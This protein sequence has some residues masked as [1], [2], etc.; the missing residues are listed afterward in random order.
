MDMRL[1]K[2]PLGR[3]GL[4]VSVLGLGG[5]HQVEATQDTIDQVVGRY[6]DAGGNYVE[7]ARG[8]GSGASEEKLGRALSGRRDR[9][10]LASKS[11]AK[12]REGAWRQINESLEALRTSYID[13]YFFHGVTNSDDLAARCSSDGALQAYVRARDEGLIRHLAFSSHW[14]MMYVEGAEQLPIEAVLIIQNYLDDCDYPETPRVVVP[15]MR[16]KGIAVL[17]MKPLGDGFLYRSPRMA[18]RYA[19]AQDADC[20][21]SGFN[22]V[23]MLEADLAACCDPTPVT[24]QEIDA[25][26]RD[27]PELSDYVC[28]QCGTCPVCEESDLLRR[29]FEL[30][31]KFDRQMDD[32]RPADAAHYA[33]RE[34]LKGWLGNQEKAQTAYAELGEPAGRLAAQAVKPC[35]FGIDIARKLEIAHAKLSRDARVELV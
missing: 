10:V 27:A 26:L 7:T 30:E 9:V 29:V 11:G 13:L 32:R 31:G 14:P 33:L 4:E 28:R 8:Y 21:V 15:A 12:N 25:I 20:I 6:L 16:A 3:T 23:D 34:R 2:R 5:F 17:L 24:E 1:P 22:S 19:L 35:R 18:L